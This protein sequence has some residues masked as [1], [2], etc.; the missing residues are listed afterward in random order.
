[1]VNFER[2]AM[3]KGY[4]NQTLS[5][6]L[7]DSG[8]SIHPVTEKIK[9]VFTGGKG[10]DLWLLW[11]AVKGTTKWTDP[12]NAVCIAS[13]P[14]CGTPAYPGS[15]KSIVTCLS[16]LTGSVIDSNV[17][18]YF[19]PYLKFSGF[20]ALKIQGKTSQDVVI[21][22][23][24]VDEKIRILE[25][26]GLPDD[27]YETSSIL[28]SHFGPTKPRSISVVTTGTGAKHTLMGCL[29]FSWYDMKRK[30]VRYKQA[31][32]GGIGTVFA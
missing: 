16:P 1:T 14:M 21:L 4:A 9:S 10:F 27:A 20:D 17:G 22:I 19:G 7:T 30:R 18:G 12:E 2:P 13:G 11:D 32:R 8:I 25:I 26:S 3:E 31:A 24:G 28:T 5:I 23:D 15:G 29:N 6:N